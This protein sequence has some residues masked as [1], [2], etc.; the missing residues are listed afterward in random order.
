MSEHPARLPDH[1]ILQ[2]A[3]E[4]FATVS[5]ENTTEQEQAEW[6]AWLKR[7]A[8]HQRAWQYVERVGQRFQRAQESVGAEGT[9]RILKNT[10]NERINRRR[11]LGSGLACLLAWLG[12][13]YTPLPVVSQ[14]LANTWMADQH[15]ATGETRQLTLA[16]GG[17]LWLNTASAV[18]IHYQQNLRTIRLRLGEILVQTAID[19]EQRPFVVTTRQGSLRA[20]G[21]RFSVKQQETNTLLVVYDGAVEIT[22]A[23]GDRQ[24][25]NAGQQ[26]LFDE[27]SIQPP[28][29]AQ[30][31]REAWAKGLILAEDISLKEL[32]A[33]LSRYR[34]GHLGVDPAVAELRVMGAY[35]INNPDHCLTMLEAALPVQ[36]NRLLPWW[37]TLEPKK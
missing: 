6:R 16:D 15:T 19:P 29:Q 37:V 30:R 14:Q 13:R 27:H 5:D 24:I 17:Q 1:Q 8:E 25:L 12:W 9:G 36:V 22:T 4:W 31:A 23:A 32:A 3:A 10:R 2:Q 11:L 33:E 28:Q 26:T 34:R 7:D 18:D 35:P 20:L 21:T